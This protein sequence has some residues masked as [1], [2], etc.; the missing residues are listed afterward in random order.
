MIRFNVLTLFPELI[1]PHLE[2]LPFKRAVEKNAAEY[3]LW[4]LRDYALDKRGTVD[5][6]PFGGGT[7]MLLMPQPIYDAL[8]DIHG[9]S[10]EDTIKKGGT[11]VILLSPRGK[12]YNQKYAEELTKAREVTLICG[13][14]EGV[15][16]RVEENYVTDIISIGDYVLSGGEVPALTILESVTRLL[17]QVI[18]KEDAVTNESFSNGSLEYPQYTRPEIFK[19]KK[20]P[21][22]LLSGN[23]KEIE[24]WK[25]D[26]SPDA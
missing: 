3:K 22:V 21:D 13:R 26:N 1:Q 25:K 10:P 16:A 7:G 5:D 6:K 9:E 12:K 24:K 18:E 14:Y 15:D 4:N 20:V 8:N 17:P 19:G 11:R 2:F 23:H